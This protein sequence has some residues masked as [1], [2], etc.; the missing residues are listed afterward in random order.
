M[1]FARILSRPLSSSASPEPSEGFVAFWMGNWLLGPPRFLLSPL[2]NVQ[3]APLADAAR[4][5]VGFPVG[6]ALEGGE[7]REGWNRGTSVALD[8]SVV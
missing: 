6:A 4:V 8:S 5:A 1:E 3:A 2:K 7:C